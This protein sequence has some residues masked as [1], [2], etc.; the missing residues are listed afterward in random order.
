MP[1][2]KGSKVWNSGTGKGWIDP[3]GYRQTRVNG[4]A[5]REHRVIME[6]HL[7]RKLEP[8]EHVH[9]KDGNKLNN[10]IENLA[11]I[12]AEEHN[13]E[14]SGLQ[15]SDQAKITMAIQ[16]TMRMEIERL[17][18]INAEMLKAL[19]EALPLI[20]EKAFGFDGEALAQLVR[21]AIARAEG[22]E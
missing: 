17:R 3:R 4:K 20:E 5:V 14:H 10:E 13:K 1:T 11:V 21:G 6:R 12:S 2:P 15:R 22:R 8:W 19:T 9:H 7:G 16:R 18:E